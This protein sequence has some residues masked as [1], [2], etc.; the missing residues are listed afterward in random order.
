MTINAIAKTTVNPF[1]DGNFAPVSDEITAENLQVIGQLPP[2]LSGMFVRNGPNPQWTPIGKYHWFDG[3][4]ML[5][6]VRINNG[7][8][9][10]RD[11]YIQTKAWKI[12]Q[13]AGK[14][15]W[16]GFL[17]PPQMDISH[18]PSKNTANTALV[19]H[20]GQLL[21]LWEG[22][23]PHAIKIPDLETVGE[24]TYDGKLVSAFTAHPKVDPL[25]GEMMFFS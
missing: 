11:R 13:A 18:G 15:I 22:G 3:D 14:A 4:G 6:G 24:Y 2:E 23:A 20:A 1:L 5:H 21:A 9:S 25:T 19:W 10:Y 16:S 8:A 17:E 7:K 12:E